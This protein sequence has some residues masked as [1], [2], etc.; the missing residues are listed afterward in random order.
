MSGCS[1]EMREKNPKLA[2]KF[3][4]QF[5]EDIFDRAPRPPEDFFERRPRKP[6]FDI[7]KSW[8]GIVKAVDIDFTFVTSGRTKDAMG[9]YNPVTDDITINLYPWR[10]GA[11]GAGG[12]K[13]SKMTDQDFIDEIIETITHEAGHAAALSEQGADLMKEL[14]NWATDV[15]FKDI[16]VNNMTQF[17]NK[18][19]DTLQIITHYLVNEYV[20][21]LIAGEDKTQA[22][23]N[24]WAQTVMARADEW[25]EL[26]I[27]GILQ[28]ER[29]RQNE[30][31]LQ[32]AIALAM[33][34]NLNG[35]FNA[36]PFTIVEEVLP[37]LDKHFNKISQTLFKVYQTGISRTVQSNWEQYTDEETRE[38]FGH[39][40]PFARTQSK[41]DEIFN[42]PDWED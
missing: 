22:L 24:A 19:S 20:A 14:H 40:F 33:Q 35:F 26:L 21:D 18:A 5:G 7:E 30:G 42:S 11:R 28:E 9:W 4:K 13:T 37:L 39:N 25:L 36:D 41:K 16:D 31:R 17:Q 29:S 10:K 38:Q 34:N 27:G 12:R 1:G 2:R 6:S 32:N 15:V 3:E 8:W 23:Q